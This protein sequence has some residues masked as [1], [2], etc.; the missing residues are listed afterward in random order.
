MGLLE[1]QEISKFLYEFYKEKYGELETDKW[2][3]Q[4]AVN[5]WVFERDGKIITL[6]CHILTGE[7]EAKEEML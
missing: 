2:F 6:K 7:V 1:K 4:P 5:V 3:E